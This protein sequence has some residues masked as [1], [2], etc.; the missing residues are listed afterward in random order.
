M[1]KHYKWILE[2]QEKEFEE[3]K[4]RHTDE[5]MNQWFQTKIKETKALIKKYE[6]REKERE[7]RK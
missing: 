1:V 3:F 6:I 7:N 4:Q 2:T 5:R